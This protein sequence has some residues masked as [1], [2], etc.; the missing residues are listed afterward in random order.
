M[1][2]VSII[3]PVYNIENFISGCIESLINQTYTNIEII[4]VDDGSTDGSA[5]LCD[6]Y[7]KKGSQIKVIHK[8]NG[9]LSSARNTGLSVAKGTYIMFVD[10][11]DYL[12]LNAV[13]LLVNLLS[14]SDT[15]FIQFDYLETESEYSQNIDRTVFNPVV[16]SNTKAIFEK[17]YDIGGAAAS[18]CTKFYKKELFNNLSFKEG[19]IHE[20]EYFTTY[21]LQNAKSVMYI[22]CKLYYYVMRQNSIVKSKFSKK[23]FDSL[24]IS[25]DRM[26]QLEK[27]GYS[28]LL[29]KEKSRYFLTAVS[30]WCSAKNAHDKMS[31]KKATESIQHIIS[32]PM[33]LTGKFKILYNLCKININLLIVYYFYKKITN[34][35]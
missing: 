23:K 31:V 26:E 15:D 5:A 7:A 27:L 33:A 4:L 13:E 21:L 11:D 14:K 22:P 8:Q 1:K 6:E 18:A 2:K 29:E 20:D 24:F 16:I 17:L 19:I 9:G 35:V 34:Q 3:V 12:S 32:K 25:L 28:D 30:L 10:G